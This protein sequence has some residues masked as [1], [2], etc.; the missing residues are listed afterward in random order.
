MD[1]TVKRFSN[2]EYES[3]L[4]G[5][6]E[7]ALWSSTDRFQGED[8]PLDQYDGEL[9]ED[10]REAMVAD[11]RIFMNK[12]YIAITKAERSRPMDYLGHDFWLT[13]CGHGAGFWCRDELSD[14]LQKVLT[15]AAER[16]GEAHIMIGDDKQLY[17]YNG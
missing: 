16:C 2:L 13:R 10:D 3:F 15:R 12:N 1:L 8:I 14:R 4:N 6:I 7:C 11:C 9:S 5:Y 17:Y